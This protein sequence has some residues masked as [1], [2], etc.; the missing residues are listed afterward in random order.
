MG[1]KGEHVPANDMHHNSFSKITDSYRP[2]PSGSGK[3][4]AKSSRR[5]GVLAQVV[6]DPKN[7][8]ALEVAIVAGFKVPKSS[9]LSGRI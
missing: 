1:V 5:R 2:L 8:M 7:A 3:E 6:V 9:R 4:I